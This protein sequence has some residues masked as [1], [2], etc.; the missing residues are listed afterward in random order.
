MKIF[1]KN[2]PSGHFK[3]TFIDIP[4]IVEFSSF[5][6]FRKAEAADIKTQFILQ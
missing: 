5:G 4:N 1:Q 2:F 3:K 6:T